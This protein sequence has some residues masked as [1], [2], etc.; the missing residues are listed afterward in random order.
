[1]QYHSIEQCCQL[2]SLPIVDSVMQIVL[3]NTSYISSLV[4]YS[5][6]VEIKHES[7]ENPRHTVLHHVE[8]NPL[9]SSTKEASVSYGKK[10]QSGV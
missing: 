1:M 3:T 6:L 7:T 10:V 5:G 8:I 4:A 9:E 2:L